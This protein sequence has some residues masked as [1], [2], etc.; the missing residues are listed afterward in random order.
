[1][2]APVLA[3]LARALANEQL[4]RTCVVCMVTGGSFVWFERVAVFCRACSDAADQPVMPEPLRA[5]LRGLSFEF[6][7][8]YF[9]FCEDD[10][11]ERVGA[12]APPV[13]SAVTA[14]LRG[15]QEP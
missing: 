11:S 3:W 12:L 2:N 6:R 9:R 5:A 4:L 13:R 7:L 8:A 1:M 10:R 14:I 15:D